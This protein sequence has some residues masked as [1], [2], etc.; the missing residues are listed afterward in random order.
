LRGKIAIALSGL[1]GLWFVNVASAGATTCSTVAACVFGTNVD[2]TASST[3]GSDAGVYASSL[4]G[5]GIDGVTTFASTSS[6]AKSGVSGVDKSTTG[7]YNNGVFGF[8]PLGTGVHGS[9]STG[10]GVAGLATSSTGVGVLA[11]SPGTALAVTS[12]NASAGSGTGITVTS[13]GTGIA[14]DTE[15]DSVDVH[16]AFGYGLAV[17]AGPEGSGVTIS[18]SENDGLDINTNG[19]IGAPYALYIDS[20]SPVQILVD[21]LMSLDYNGNLTISGKLTQHGIPTTDALTTAGRSLQTYSPRE[22]EATIEDVGE[23]TVTNGRGTVALDPSF[24]STFDQRRPYYVFLSAEGDNRGLY[25]TS[26]TLR[27]FSIRESNAGASTLAVQ[28]RI[29]A[30]PYDAAQ[31]AR[32]AIVDP[33]TMPYANAAA[34]AHAAKIRSL[35][36]QRRAKLAETFT[37]TP[38]R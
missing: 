13:A 8:S 22:A 25:V 14:V 11:K 5:D 21:N 1:V 34:R 18:T 7:K 16:S 24:A 15:V 4:K 36:A 17:D 9:T 29:V 28:Y 10:T 23:T 37:A 35:T 30:K 26:K 31:T 19:S 27:G 3:F 12:S 33:T 20:N 2:G 6:L 38:Q 32:L